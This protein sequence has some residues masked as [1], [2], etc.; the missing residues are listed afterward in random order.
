MQQWVT[1]F[2]DAVAKNKVCLE[3][4]LKLQAPPTRTVRFARGALVRTAGAQGCALHSPQ[5]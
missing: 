1:S 2:N 3:F 5:R 4:K